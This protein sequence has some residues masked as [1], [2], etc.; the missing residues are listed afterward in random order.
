M[1]TKSLS[2]V[3]AIRSALGNPFTLVNTLVGKSPEDVKQLITAFRSITNLHLDVEIDKKSW[4]SHIKM[5][6]LSYLKQL[7]DLDAAALVEAFE[8]ISYDEHTLIEILCT[9]N[10]EQ[11]AQIS[12]SFPVVYANK[13]SNQKQS[14]LAALEDE[15]SGAEE[16]LFMNLAR[17]DRKEGY[18]NEVI[19][20]FTR[21]I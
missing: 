9:R 15:L 20:F 10:D 2:D 14:L 3:Q 1:E 11:I 13:N 17:H 7:S 19:H 16:T 12:S 5:A 4:N 8:G 6:L 18:R 21:L